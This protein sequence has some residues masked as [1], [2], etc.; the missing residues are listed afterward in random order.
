MSENLA[1][2]L[3]LVLC[4]LG[5]AVLWTALFELNRRARAAHLRTTRASRGQAPVRA[6]DMAAIAAY[7]RARATSD[8]TDGSLDDRTWDDLNMNDVFSVLDRT[9]SVVGQHVSRDQRR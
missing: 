7:H 5:V 2:P 8:P 1:M 6:R 4:T 3:T 9:E